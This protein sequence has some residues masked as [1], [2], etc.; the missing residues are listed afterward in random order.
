[1][2]M[3]IRHLKVIAEK[4]RLR[5]RSFLQRILKDLLKPQSLLMITAVFVLLST[6]LLSNSRAGFM[7]TI[8]GMLALIALS[9]RTMRLPRWSKLL[10]GIVLFGMLAGVVVGSNTRTFG[11]MSTDMAEEGRWPVYEILVQA[12][13]DAPVTG[14]GLGNFKTVFPLYRD[15]TVIGYYDRAHND[16]LEL[17]FE[18]GI[19][20]AF[21]FYLSILWVVVLCWKGMNRRRQQKIYP[22][23]AVAASVLVGAHAIIDFSLQMPSISLFY[24]MILGLGYGQSG[25]SSFKEEP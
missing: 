19:P 14:F 2:A 15:H 3:W 4:A 12:I 24:V 7:S 16:Y 17:I 5:R 25:Y 9:L 21:L 20:A 11:R 18:L 6:V 1:M 8:A 23:L 13:T 22:T 10:L